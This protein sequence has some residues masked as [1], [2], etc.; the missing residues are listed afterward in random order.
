MAMHFSTCRQDP[1]RARAARHVVILTALAAFRLTFAS[2]AERRLRCAE[3]MG[4]PVGDLDEAGR[5]QALP[6]ALLSLMQDI[7]IPNGLTAAT[8]SAVF[9]R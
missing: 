7:G 3:L 6:R 9:P 2:A 4:V 5:Y 8:P 1:A